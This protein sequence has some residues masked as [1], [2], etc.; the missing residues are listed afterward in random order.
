[1]HAT[2]ATFLAGGS[3]RPPLSKL[4]AYASLFLSSS[5]VWLMRSPRPVSG[6]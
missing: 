5:S 1:M 2:T 4:E 3:G 6:S